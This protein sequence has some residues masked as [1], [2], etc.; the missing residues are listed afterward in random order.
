MSL[1]GLILAGLALLVEFIKL[2][3]QSHV[4]ISFAN[5]PAQMQV[6]VKVNGLEPIIPIG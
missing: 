6:L 3:K 2:A 1:Y 5:A 4:A